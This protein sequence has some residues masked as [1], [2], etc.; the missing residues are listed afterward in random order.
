MET[1]HKTRPLG[2]GITMVITVLAALVFV[3]ELVLGIVSV[4]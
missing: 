3:L 2:G 4:A 1:T